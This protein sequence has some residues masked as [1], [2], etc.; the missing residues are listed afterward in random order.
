M[1]VCVVLLVVVLSCKYEGVLLVEDSSLIQKRLSYYKRVKLQVAHCSW[2]QQGM[3]HAL[4]VLG[5][6]CVAPAGHA[7]CSSCAW[8]ILLASRARYI[9]CWAYTAHN[10]ELLAPS[11]MLTA[12]EVKK[13]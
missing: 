13:W 6:F 9:P 4:L 10:L 3:Q 1:K 7:A 5:K 8:E 11:F 2:H 12:L